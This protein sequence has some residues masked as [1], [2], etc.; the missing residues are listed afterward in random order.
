MGGR[1]SLIRM[2][3][4]FPSLFIWGNLPQD[5]L[6]CLINENYISAVNALVFTEFMVEFDF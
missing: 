4:Y 3:D 1:Y 2:N 5:K 6:C